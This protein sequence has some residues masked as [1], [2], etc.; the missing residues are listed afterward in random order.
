MQIE[1]KITKKMFESRIS[2]GA[3]EKLP[4]WEE[5]SAKTLVCSH[6]MEGHAKMCVD[7]FC[8]LASIK[9]E[10][11]YKVSTP[12]LKRRTGNGWRI[13]QSVLA[14]CLDV[15]VFGQNW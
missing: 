7:N 1:L 11:L 8:E 12:C 5:P 4:G 6:D 3:T 14:N 2:A 10:Q 15:L 13:V 9:T